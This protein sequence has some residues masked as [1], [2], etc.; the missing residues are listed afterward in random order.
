[1]INSLD[2]SNPTQLLL[3]AIEHTEAASIR[4]APT[5]REEEQFAL[6]VLTPA[7]DVSWAIRLPYFFPN[8]LSLVD[9]AGT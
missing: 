3:R 4:L 6:A 2:G 7:G 8:S 1:M 5:F 9:C